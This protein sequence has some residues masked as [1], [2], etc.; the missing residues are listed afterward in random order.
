[1]A[2]PIEDPDPVFSQRA[3]LD[4]VLHL[5]TTFVVTTEGEVEDIAFDRE[6]SACAEPGSAAVASFERAVRAALERWRYFGAAVC[7]FP[8]GIDP[9]SDPRCDGPDVRVDPVPIRMR[10]VFTF[11]SERGGRVSRA[12]ASPV[13]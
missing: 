13:K 7:T 4:G 2:V 6:S 8:D 9:D 11:S 5:C 3:Q 10:Y 1:M 12:Q